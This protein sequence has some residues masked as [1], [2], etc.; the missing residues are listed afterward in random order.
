MSV[1][2]V[3]W[4]SASFL[5][6]LGGITI[7][8]AL[9]ALLGIESGEHGSAGLA[10]WALL[11]FL[12]VTASAVLARAQGHRVTAGLLALSSIAAYVVLIGA[13]LDWL[14]W[15]APTTSAFGGFRVSVLFLE[16]SVV[17]AG[18]VA[19]AVF[20]FPLLV[21]VVAA[22]TWFFLTDLLSGGGDWSAVLA[23]LIGL[24]MLAAALAVD[25]GATRPY[26]LWLH[27]VAGL[28]I[29]GGL[30]WF[31]HDGDLA[32]TTVA[33]V[34]L[35]YI[36]LGDRWMRSSWVVLG[37]WG[38]LQAAGYFALKLGA[39]A[40]EAFFVFFYF[41][42]FAIA[43]AFESGFED[44]NT[45]EWAAPA[46]FMFTGVLFVGIG[47]LLVRRRREKIAGAELL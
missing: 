25:R 47:L 1:A 5:V 43:N 36:A 19:L 34:G 8:A 12:A 4:S 21:L 6:Y 17:V 40:S 24:A 23:I 9:A 18:G 22:G 41:F 3:P 38:I 37:A 29:G 35:G 26:A 46:V 11:V 32:W 33:L 20:R 7:L 44:R 39:T 31:L 2:R 16:L 45:H 30:L 42:P 14:G 27:V 15:L 28:T 13:L 10:G